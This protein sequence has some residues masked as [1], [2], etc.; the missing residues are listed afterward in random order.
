MHTI[1]LGVEDAYE[2]Y[3]FYTKDK[4]FELEKQRIN[5]KFKNAN[6]LGINIVKQQ[7]TCEFIK[8]ELVLKKCVCILLVDANKLKD[9]TYLD[10]DSLS[11]TSS[12]DNDCN[13]ISCCLFRQS[14][15]TSEKNDD[16]FVS[17]SN[18]LGHFIVVIGFDEIKNIIYFRCVY[19]LI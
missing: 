3:D 19:N 16:N 11:L 6:Q 4:N 14:K 2:T 12:D 10:N 5:N 15:T 18:Y 13:K 8:M 7:V 1:T 17:N 9:A